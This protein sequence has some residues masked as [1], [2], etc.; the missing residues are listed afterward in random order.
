MNTNYIEYLDTLDN[1]IKQID[2]LKD[3]IDKTSQKYYHGNTPADVKTYVDALRNLTEKELKFVFDKLNSLKATIYGGAAEKFLRRDLDFAKDNAGMEQLLVN[4]QKRSGKEWTTDIDILV[5]LGDKSN[6]VMVEIATLLNKKAG[7]TQY[8]PVKGGG[9]LD[10]GLDGLGKDNFIDAH[11]E[12]SGTSPYQLSS[13]VVY[14][15]QSN[16]YPVYLRE[17]AYTDTGRN[18]GQSVPIEAPGLTATRR[19]TSLVT[20]DFK[21]SL[22]PEMFNDFNP[23]RERFGLTPLTNSKN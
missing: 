1:V 21:D 17:N 13:R 18:F 20:G 11:L 22:T 15:E 19:V 9:I 23:R 7:R 5:K 16:P 10:I 4:L 12:P 8:I 3:T 6:K 14:G 2:F